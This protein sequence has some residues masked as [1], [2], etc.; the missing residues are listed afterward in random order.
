MTGTA[1]VSSRAWPCFTI[2]LTSSTPSLLASV[3]GSL[4]SG[5]MEGSNWAASARA[6]L[7][8]PG[9]PPS[10]IIKQAK[11][12]ARR[13]R[14]MWKSS[15]KG[16]VANQARHESC[17]PDC[18]PRG[19]QMLPQAAS[20]TPRRLASHVTPRRRPARPALPCIRPLPGAGHAAI[21]A[22][23]ITINSIE[24]RNISGSG[25]ERAALLHPAGCLA[26]ERTP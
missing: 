1:T 4:N 8:C 17:Q 23:I 14:F 13:D 25:S 26:P 16:T 15:P 2:N 18:A 21:Y 12:S 6:G 22:L 11:P 19:R 24:Y 3:T 9:A 20:A 10:A 7:M 5:R